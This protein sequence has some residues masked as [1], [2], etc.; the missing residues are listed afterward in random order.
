MA[1]EVNKLLEIVTER[2]DGVFWM[3]P[4]TASGLASKD[5]MALAA[6]PREEPRHAADRAFNP[7]EAPCAP[8]GIATSAVM[9][10]N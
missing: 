5:S 4:T 8:H 7:A 1:A 3:D 2:E 6:I 9:T 10:A